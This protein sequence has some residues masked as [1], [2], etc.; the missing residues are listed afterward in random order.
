MMAL[1]LLA[2]GTGLASENERYSPKLFSGLRYHM[3]G[4]SRGGRVT[5]V[6]GHRAQLSTFYMGA[7]GG[8][9]WKTTD[10][11]QTWHP[12]SDGFFATGSIGAIRVAESNPDIVYVST[13]SDGLRSNVIIGKGVYKSKDAG[14]TWEHLGLEKT[15]NS[16]A[17]LIHP[18][19]PDLAYVAAIGNPFASN[20]ERGVYR[21]EDG[22]STWERVLFVSDQTGAVDLEFAPDDPRLIYAT[23]WR[24]ERKPWT[25][26][27]GGHEGGVYKSTDGG[28]TWKPLSNGL[29][30]G[31]RGKSDLAVSAGDPDRV[32][33]LIEAP[34]KEGGV[35]RSDDRGE[36]F[37]QVSDFKPIQNRPFYY[38]NL[39]AHPR[40]PDILWGMAEGH[41]KSE[42][43][44]KT[45]K[46]E[47]TPH[48]DN[49]DMWINPDE[50][51][52]LIQ[53]N[54]GG[55]NVTLNGGKT[56]S[57]QY[58]QPTAELYQV[59]VS[60]VFP[61]RLYAGQQD[62]STISVPTFP[63]RDMPGGHTALWESQGGCETG[64][65]VPRPGD[66]D[67][68]F[69][70][71]KGRFG[72]Y[73]RR[74]GQEQQYY[75]GFENLYGHNPRD[76]K[77]R[78][79]RVAPIHVSPHN[80]NRVYHTSQYVHVTEDGGITWE[81]ISPDL[82]AFTPE[83][84][85]ISG[86]PIT[87]DVTGEEH[88]SVIYEV[89]ESPHERGV[90]WVGAND[91]PIHLTRDGGKNWKEVTPQGVGPYGRVQTIE[92]SPHRP[93]KAYAAI[94]R[95]QLGD[96]T[97]HLY[98]TENYG[99][100]WTRITDGANGIPGD[101]PVRV[102]RE[103]RER[104]G[105]LYAGTEFGMFVSFD[106]GARWQSL[107]L[108]LPVTPVTD[109][110]IVDH[111]LA[112]S[113]M[114]RSFWML[115]DLTP[116]Q[117]ID[118][119][120]ASS[121]AHLY[122]VN[123]P[124]RLRMP[125]RFDPEAPDA[126]QYPEPGANID[127][128]LAEEPEGEVTLEILDASGELVRAFSSQAEGEEDV[129]PEP[130]SMREFRLER[131]GTPKL[132]KG[133]GMHRFSW[134][135]RHPGPWSKDARRSGRGGPLVAPG[136]YQARLSIGDWSETVSFEARMD[137]RVVAEGRVSEADVKAQ[138]ELALEARDAL[139]EGRLAAARLERALEGASSDDRAKLLTVQNALVAAPIRYSRPMI[140]DQI[141][142]L[143]ENLDTADQRPGKDAYDRFEE[144]TAELQEQ[145]RALDR[146]LG[147]TD[148][149]GKGR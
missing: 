131:V 29:P 64:P 144:L 69:A 113:T 48:G 81:T 50:P 114:G 127:Y 44:G 129:V 1:L 72:L 132:P 146:V 19:N 100:S 109:L 22:G 43:A 6:A 92:I 124:L 95:Y 59:D 37:R 149:S 106:D 18:E 56:W 78:F 26:V 49:H 140:V 9:V 76:L 77:Y 36:S 105:L 52:I 91:G 55:A 47:E 119:R 12:V 42:D 128:Y 103:D 118:A 15:G 101:Q 139:S 142:Y 107:Q 99:E 111:D 60:D 137:P 28:D 35:Y 89:R 11:G 104:E 110:E 7:T 53:S 117:Q 97:P 33:V 62:N 8:G 75:V 115:Y 66:P 70:D 34:G 4:P 93:A 143:Y 32:Y 14:K 27:S 3:V 80:P 21:T 134:D 133:A 67:V 5:A 145:L 85:V 74:T 94:L 86:S 87:I 123:H 31:L 79:Q 148:A 121:S 141:E 138:V 96:F 84:Q 2:A 39:E 46:R 23:M 71:C 30:T 63:P 38:C 83:T 130:A 73:N 102:V 17:V 147:T 88:F 90:I 82:T 125:M 57:T 98:K 65:V 41:Y 45:W 10:F 20:P 136:R 24:A 16:G 13:G 54:D 116:L 120:V 58:N 135:L 112:V 61:Y 126:P 51:D 122:Q 25:I 108:N 40:N 68:V